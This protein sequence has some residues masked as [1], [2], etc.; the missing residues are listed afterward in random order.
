V[1]G[2]PTKGG[3]PATLEEI[4]MLA[5]SQTNDVPRGLNRRCATI[6]HPVAGEA[7]S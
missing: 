1:L 2:D 6:R 4:V 3:R 5:G 7:K